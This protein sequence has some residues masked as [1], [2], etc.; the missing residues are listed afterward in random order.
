MSEE[1]KWRD[2]G[3]MEGSKRSQ[4]GCTVET[5]GMSKQIVPNESSQRDTTNEKVSGTTG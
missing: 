1:G 3:K 5:N 2:A 4:D